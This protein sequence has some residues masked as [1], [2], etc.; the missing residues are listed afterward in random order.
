MEQASVFGLR[1]RYFLILLSCSVLLVAGF[2]PGMGGAPLGAA[3]NLHADENLISKSQ[4]YEQLLPRLQAQGTLRVIMRLE[5][6][7]LPEAMH[8]SAYAILAQR[9]RIQQTQNAVLDSLSASNV[10]IARVYEHVPYMALEIDGTA[11]RDLIERSRRLL[12]KSR[13]DA[14]QPD[15]CEFLAGE[16]DSLARHVDDE[17]KK[18]EEGRAREQRREA[19]DRERA[20]QLTFDKERKERL[21]DLTQQAARLSKEHRYG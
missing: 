5:M 3:S 8:S 12:D 2:S 16:L 15:R 7:F 11:L 13:P 20:A 1:R 6:P 21:A 9:Y 19:P 10:V 14:E 18:H 17:E 4:I